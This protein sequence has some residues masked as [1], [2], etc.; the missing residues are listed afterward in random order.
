M[1]ELDK[2]GF[3]CI[4]SLTYLFTCSLIPP[5]ILQTF[6]ENQKA[7]VCCYF[8]FKDKVNPCQ[9]G[10]VYCG[11]NQH[12]VVTILIGLES[13]CAGVWLGGW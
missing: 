9:V 2:P 13:Q 3:S 5:F 7:P 6:L 12:E 11:G 8:K 10:C 1:L 4:N